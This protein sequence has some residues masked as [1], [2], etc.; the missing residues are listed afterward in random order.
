MESV[1]ITVLA[2]EAPV[3]AAVFLFCLK[4]EGLQGR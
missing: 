2:L 3:V 1:D 4:L